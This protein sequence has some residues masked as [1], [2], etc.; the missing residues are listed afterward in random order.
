ML[1]ILGLDGACWEIIEPA[2]RLGK[3]PHLARLRQSG[4]WGTLASTLPPVTFPA[5]TSFATGVNPGKHGI[6][7]FTQRRFGSY[8]VR[9]VNATARQVPTVWARLSAAGRRQCIVGIPSSF[10]P[11]PIDGCMVSGFDTPVTTR[12]D[13]SFVHPPE[14]AASVL[15]GG[16]FPFA[17]FQ[18]FRVGPGWHQ[19]ARDRLLRGVETKTRLAKRLLGRGPWDVFLML[20]GESDTVAHHFWQVH[21]P[22]SPRFDAALAAVL[23][24]T[25]VEVYEALDDAIGSLIGAADPETVLL[26]SDHGFGGVGNKV[27]YLNRWLAQRGWQSRHG[28]SSL[29]SPAG[30]LKRQAL[31][32][33]PTGWQA[34]LFRLAGGAFAS[35]LE[36]RARFAHIDWS[37][38]RVFSEELGYAPSFWI[39]VA[40]R[41]PYGTVAACDYEAL[42]SE[43][44]ADVTA[45]RDPQTGRAI[46]RRAWRREEVLHGAHV[47]AAPDILLELDLDEGYSYACAASGPGADGA[48]VA[49]RSPASQGGKLDGMAGSHRRQGMYLISGEA[50]VAGRRDANIEDMGATILARCGL[51]VPGDLD[52]RSVLA[53]APTFGAVGVDPAVAPAAVEYSADEERE[54]EAR[55]AALGYLN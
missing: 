38:T 30:W 3:L 5:W 11:E 51:Q 33:V 12:A 40:G 41:D 6:F 37:R 24:D 55:L 42:R 9:F 32:R 35:R 44:I 25:V 31:S 1:L 10:P 4:Q 27:L 21:D 54:I 43:V 19:Q 8:E 52:G 39:H 26:A 23:G 22:A 13:A 28:A 49:Q 36:S 16:G 18:E 50:I 45:W 7:D 20:F 29:P 53:A 15:G 17:D 48:C 47:E 46:V 14:W 34:K 2:L